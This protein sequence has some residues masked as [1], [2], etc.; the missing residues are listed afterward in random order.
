MQAIVFSRKQQT[1][2]TKNNN[3]PNLP[4][5]PVLMIASTQVQFLILT[6]Q[7]WGDGRGVGQ[8]WGC[9]W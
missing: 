9:R 3:K 8:V 2:F 6:S 1:K 4:N 5:I 7:N